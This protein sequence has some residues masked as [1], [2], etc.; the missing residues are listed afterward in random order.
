MLDET[1]FLAAYGIHSLS[2]YHKEN[3]YSMEVNGQVS[4]VPGDSDNGHFGGNCNWRGPIWVA[5]NQLLVGS[6]VRYHM[7]YTCI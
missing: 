3:L 6:L 1:E 7:F 4:Y 2:K 5:V